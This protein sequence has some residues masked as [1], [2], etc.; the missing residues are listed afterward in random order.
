MKKIFFLFFIL[1]IAAASSLQAEDLKIAAGAGYKKS[2]LKIIN[3]YREQYKTDIDGIFGNMK[4]VS[5][6]ARQTEIAMVIGDRDYLSKKSKLN[7]IQFEEIGEGKLVLAYPKNAEIKTFDQLT[8]TKIKRVAMPQPQ[9]AIFGTAGEAF[10]NNSGLYNK[11]K[12]KLYVVAT[13]PQVATYLVANEVDAG[14]MNLTAALENREKLGGYI[15]IPQKYYSKVS[16]VAGVLP[17]CSENKEC[18]QFIDFLHTKKSKE[19]FQH[20]GL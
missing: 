15:A 8:D 12:D 5:A 20:Y 14:I 9:K 19:I 16:I 3:M 17:G 13:V 4:Q 1:G 11:I 7:F 10:L 2:I 18:R 6:Q